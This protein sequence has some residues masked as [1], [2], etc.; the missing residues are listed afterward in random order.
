[1]LC[2][3][4]Y[5]GP[6][7][8]LL[9]AIT[10]HGKQRPNISLWMDNH[11][12]RLWLTAAYHKILC[13]G[14]STSSRTLKMSV[15]CFTDTEWDITC[16][17]TTNKLIQTSYL[18]RMSVQAD[19]CSSTVYRSLKVICNGFS[20]N[21]WKVVSSCLLQ[22]KPV[23]VINFDKLHC[24]MLKSKR[25][26]VFLFSYSSAHRHAW[27]H[28]RM[29]LFLFALLLRLDKKLFYPFSLLKSLSVWQ[30]CYI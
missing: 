29:C 12:V 8:L 22:Y 7:E 19:V 25:L 30:K 24:K 10:S 20:Q 9:S 15:Q 5:K 23:Y 1:V 16:T 26:V 21:W 17:L 27:R 6:A 13:W 3:S 18:L 28:I 14:Q 11:L 2:F 4:K